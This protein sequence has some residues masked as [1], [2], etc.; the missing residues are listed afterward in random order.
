MRFH[1][2]DCF[3]R[4]GLLRHDRREGFAENLRPRF[5]GANRFV[6]GQ[7]RAFQIHGLPSHT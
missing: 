6:R 2:R 4:D 1:A 5:A 3:L 7:E